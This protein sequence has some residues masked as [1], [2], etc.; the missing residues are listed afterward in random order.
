MRLRLL[1]VVFSVL[2]Q[3]I[4]RLFLSKD[5]DIV[6]VLR[7][8]RQHLDLHVDLNL[9]HALPKSIELFLSEAWQATNS[10]QVTDGDLGTVYNENLTPKMSGKWVIEESVTKVIIVLSEDFGEE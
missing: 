10:S 7:N 2:D 9:H 8:V 6:R 4:V 3:V 1:L 5:F